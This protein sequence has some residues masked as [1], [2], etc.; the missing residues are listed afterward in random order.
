MMEQWRRDIVAEARKFVGVPFFHAGR[1]PNGV[2]CVGLLSISAEA[3][4]LAAYDNVDYSRIVDSQYMQAELEKCMVPLDG[5]QRLLPGDV[6]LFMIGRSPQHVA[7][8]T[9]V[10]GPYSI[11]MIH[12][13]QTVGRVVEHDMD[14]PWRERLIRYYRW[15]GM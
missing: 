2:D 15:S 3:A 14:K 8:I 1:S 10:N 6:A 11:R 12:S 9:E 5:A 4:G 7:L 13:Y